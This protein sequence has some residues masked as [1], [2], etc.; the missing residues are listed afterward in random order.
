MLSTSGGGEQLI[1]FF[2]ILALMLAAGK[3]SGELFERLGQP[4][5]LGELIAGAVLGTSLLGLIPTGSDPLAGIIEILAE[6]GVVILLF[7]I[8]LETDLK[9][10][11]RV[12]PAASSIAMVGV[13]LPF[14]GGALFWFTP[15]VKPEYNVVAESTTAIFVGAALTATSVGITARV[16]KD[17]GAMGSIEARLIIGA[18]VIDDVLGLVI[19]GLVAS[20]AAGGAVTFLGVSRALGAAVGFLVIAVA[21][22]LKLAPRIF[23]LIDRMRVRGVLLVSAFAFTLLV[24]ALA[25]KAGSAMI[26]GAFASG[27]ILS[28][29]NQFN[30]IESRIKPVS[31]IFTPIFFLSIGAQL[32]VR[33]LN[34]F[35]PESRAVLVLGLALLAIGIVGKLLAG[36]AAPWREFSR[37]TVGLGMMPRG[38]VG[39]IFANIGLITGVLSPEVFGAILVM[40]IGTTFLA[41]PLLK[42][43]ISRH[44]ARGN[45]G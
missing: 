4:S 43:Q 16:L 2:F 17:L 45:D 35:D 3:L 24:S 40:I 10:M 15:L 41:P 36:F 26:I 19:L 9:E 27:I 6:I 20:L 29:T 7:E 37:T 39:L 32:D 30:A 42:W 44:R 21:L 34:P 11:F 22:G 18:A 8:G 5:V 25:D 13:A 38:E 33:L 1:R 31:D 23:G 14:V 28:G 12:G